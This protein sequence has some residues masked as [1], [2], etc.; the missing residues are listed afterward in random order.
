MLVS[1]FSL[2]DAAKVNGHLRA[3]MGGEGSD[4]KEEDVYGG[5]TI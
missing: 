5:S 2:G 3:R 4:G 1:I